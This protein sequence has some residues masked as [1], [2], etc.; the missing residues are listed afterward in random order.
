MYPSIL[1]TLLT[2]QLLSSS[3]PAILLRHLITL[4]SRMRSFS[5]A[6]CLSNDDSDSAENCFSRDKSSIFDVCAVTLLMHLLLCQLP[7]ERDGILT[8]PVH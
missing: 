3:I 5:P 1:K 6:S 4:P 8:V 2:P 7:A